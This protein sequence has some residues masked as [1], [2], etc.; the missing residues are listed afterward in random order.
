MKIAIYT[1]LYGEKDVLRQPLDY[2]ENT[3]IDYYIFTDKDSHNT[4]PYKTFVRPAKF[5]DVA[6]NARYYKILGDPILKEY[7]KDGV[8]NEKAEKLIEELASE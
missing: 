1:A 4:P 3:H 2:F 7:V 8:L 5:P 6:K